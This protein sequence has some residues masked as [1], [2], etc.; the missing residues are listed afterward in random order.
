MD[1]EALMDYMVDNKMVVNCPTWEA[2]KIV[3]DKLKELNP[4]ANTLYMSREYKA[5]HWPYALPKRDPYRWALASLSWFAVID[6][7]DFL[8][9]CDGSQDLCGVSVDLTEVV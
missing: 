1:Y 7:Q 5:I 9:L 2:R 4:D 8:T 3:I 6:I